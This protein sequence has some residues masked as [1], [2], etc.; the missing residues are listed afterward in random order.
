MDYPSAALPVG[1]LIEPTADLRLPLPGPSDEQ[2]QS[3]ALWVDGKPIVQ[4]RGPAPELVLPA[5]VLK[6]GQRVQWRLR[7]GDVETAGEVQVR[8]AREA[9]DLLRDITTP[10]ADDLALAQAQALAQAGYR[11]DAR[12]RLTALVAP[13]P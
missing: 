11:W 12:S 9:G 6:A 8:P 4:Q 10:Q 1:L 13:A 3:F 5:A 2:L 7:Y